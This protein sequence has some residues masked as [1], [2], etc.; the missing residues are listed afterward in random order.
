MIYLSTLTS[1]RYTKK[2]SKRRQP[3][4]CEG[5]ITKNTFIKTSHLA[6][7]KW[8]LKCAIHDF[9]ISDSVVHSY[10]ATQLPS[11]INELMTI[12]SNITSKR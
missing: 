5:C 12:L 2:E 4:V 9:K 1:Y 10:L 7:P 8:N 3:C 6:H 11:I